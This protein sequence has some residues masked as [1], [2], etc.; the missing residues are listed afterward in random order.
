M[1]V[2]SSRLIFGLVI[3]VL[4]VLILLSNLGVPIGV[5]RVWSY[6]PVIPLILGLNWMILAFRSVGSAEGR[7]VYFS[8][9]QFLTALIALAIGV[10]YLGRN[11]ALF[12]VDTSILWRLFWPV[13]LILIGVSLLRGRSVAGQSGGRFALMGGINVGGD[14]PWKLENSSY[15]ALMGGIELDLR[16]A[17]I[18]PGETVLD[19]TAIM[20][21]VEVIIP[22]GLPVVYEGSAV[23][24]GVEFLGQE[25]GGL[26]A[27]RTIERLGDET[28]TRLLRIQARTIMGGIEIKEG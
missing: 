9:G 17:D 10:V 6:W 1:R 23:L 15:T 24:G 20:G 28:E 3:L 14:A 26:I 13:L 2:V 11:L 22:R 8:W 5:D 19:L 21:G 25:D 18:S 16:T 4:G 7:R 12:E 27:S